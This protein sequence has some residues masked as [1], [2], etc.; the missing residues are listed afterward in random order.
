MTGHNANSEQMYIQMEKLKPKFN[1]ENKRFCLRL[2]SLADKSTPSVD[3]F[4][5]VQHR[6]RIGLNT[7]KAVPY[8]SG[9]RLCDFRMKRSG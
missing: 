7:S 1:G 6:N 2:H 9:R 5:S 8:S 3:Y 4:N